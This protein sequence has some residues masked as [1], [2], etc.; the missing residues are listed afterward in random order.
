MQ[1]F[2]TSGTSNVLSGMIAAAKKAAQ[3]RP[4]LAELKVTFNLGEVALGFACPHT[5][6][7]SDGSLGSHSTLISMQSQLIFISTFPARL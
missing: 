6:L 5:C 2:I 4:K 7:I 1:F 3:A